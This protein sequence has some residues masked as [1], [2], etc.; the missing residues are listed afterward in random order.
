MSLKNLNWIKLT[1]GLLL[2]TILSL[3]VHAVMIQGMNI[4]F[5]DLS[6]ISAPY[7]FIIQLFA[8]LGLIYFWELAQREINGSFFKQLG[9]L[10][11]IDAMLTESLLRGPFMDGYCT[12]SFV[13]MFVDNV[14]KLLTMATLCGLV[15][16]IT[17]L[18]KQ[19][20]KKVVASAV[21]AALFMFAITPIMGAVWSPVMDALDHL[22]P[23]SEWCTLPY[24]PDVLVPA[25]VSFIEPAIACLIMAVLVW[26]QLSQTKWI[27][28]LSF[29]LLVLAIKYQLL[30]PLFY[31]VF[32]SDTFLTNLASEGQ[33]A[34]EALA[35]A[36]L[37]G[38]TFEWGSKK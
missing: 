18:L 5:P 19:F 26:N 36:L 38:F 35:L 17:P 15:V 27:K 37:T 21:L 13:F 9:I 4:P 25:Y 7:K 8:V 2:A 12:N 31:A 24:G 32:G 3:S 22:A 14:P 23:T 10:F 33:F 11:L 29:T 6:V 16:L 1:I 28:Y 30:M 20:W 34:L